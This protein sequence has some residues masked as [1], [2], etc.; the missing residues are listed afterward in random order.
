VLRKI[1]VVDDSPVIQHVYKLFLAHYRGTRLVRALDG[2]DALERLAQEPEIDLILL[3]INM[4][5]MNGLELL[6]R[7]KREPAYQRIPVIVITTQG[8]ED[9]VKRCLAIG[10]DAYLMKPLKAA[11]L[12]ALIERTTGAKPG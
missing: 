1:L 2:L 7:L 8:R 3:D 4:P 10:A 5:V 12:D 11:D 6:Q 9:D